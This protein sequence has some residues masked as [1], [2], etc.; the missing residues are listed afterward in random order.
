MTGNGFP[1]LCP[2][3]R[4]VSLQSPGIILSLLLLGAISALAQ[5]PADSWP[6]F[7]GSLSLRGVTG[8]SL[9]AP[10]ELRW[11]YQAEDSIESSAA[12]TGGTVFVGSMD[13]ALHAID[14][15]TGKVEWKYKT[16]GPVQE[17]SPGVSDGVV[18][19]GDL[20]ATLHAVDIET[21]KARWTFTAGDE[22]RSSPVPAGDRVYFGSYD[23]HL[24][25][26]SA[27]DGSLIWKYETE[28]P[29]HGTPAVENDAVYISG[30]DERLRAI[31]AT[32]GKQVF[33][34][35]LGAYAGA[36]TAVRDGHAYL[37]TFGNE[38]LGIDLGRR[39][40]A[41]VYTHPTR[42]FPFYSSAALTE[43]YVVLGGRDKMVHCLRR[44]NGKAVWT[45]MTG[46][47]VESS[48]LIAGNRVFVGSNDGKLYELDL[49]T[50]KK[51]GEFVAGAALSASPAAGRGALVIGSQDGMLYCFGK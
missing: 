4:R 45:F 15:A 41:W 11:S 22:I 8:T 7:R 39:V 14:L 24:Y 1:G 36:S 38:V 6:L 31:S 18:Y 43:Q 2:R 12:I 35:P 23:Q 37:G 26:L 25:C 10:L 9:P 46:A 16:A 51:N 42:S 5:S 21:G 28:G 20:G 33:E 3:I 47:R 13:G 30:C 27:S 29:V 32:T 50:G 17:S 44:D 34:F 48:P 49:A 19:I 40:A